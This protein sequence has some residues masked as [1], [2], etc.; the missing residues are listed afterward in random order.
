MLRW[1]EGAC[2]SD[3][4]V[5]LTTQRALSQAEQQ[6][7]QHHSD[8][9]HEQ[10]HHAAP[11]TTQRGLPEGRQLPVHAVVLGCASEYFRIRLT[12][13][14]GRDDPHAV[15]APDGR[16]VL[17][18]LVE[19]GLLGADS[20]ARSGAPEEEQQGAAGDAAMPPPAGQEQQQQE[21][22]LAAAEAVLRLMYEAEVPPGTLA[23]QLVLMCRVSDR[24][25]AAGCMSKVG[26]AS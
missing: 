12:T 1:G 9:Q 26:P 19:E 20:T 23:R 7:R 14:H 4:T 22:A 21:E 5:L 3:V 18:E 13:A 6:P 17:L 11:P 2:W 16:L 24:W 8:H 15:K 25:Q 10:S